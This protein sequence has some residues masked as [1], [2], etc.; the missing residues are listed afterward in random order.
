MSRCSKRRGG[1]GPNRRGAF[2]LQSGLARFS[3]SPTESAVILPK[4]AIWISQQ[5]VTAGTGVSSWASYLGGLACTMV[6][7]T[8]GRQPAYSA[9]GGVGG[10]PLITTDGVDDFIEGPINKGDAWNNIEMG[11]AGRRVAFGTAGD[12]WILHHQSGS[13]VA[14]VRDASATAHQMTTSTTSANGTSDPDGNNAMWAGSCVTN[15]VVAWKNGVAEG[16]TAS[17]S[18]GPDGNPRTV[19]VGGRVV[20]AAYSNIAI[21][22]AF[23]GELLTTEQRLYLRALLTFYTGINC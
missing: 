5:G 1:A 2:R 23:T 6:Q 3:F 17:G 15:S 4:S 7:A 16:T 20:T 11:V 10:R 9:S 21:Q 8:V 18:F 14:G 12:T 13:F 22:A 19:C